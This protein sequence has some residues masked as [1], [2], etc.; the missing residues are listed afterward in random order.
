MILE[1]LFLRGKIDVNF[2]IEIEILSFA[3]NGRICIVLK[4]VI[5]RELRFFINTFEVIFRPKIA[6]NKLYRIALYVCF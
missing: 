1:I 6:K 3:R 5:L 2:E 4:I